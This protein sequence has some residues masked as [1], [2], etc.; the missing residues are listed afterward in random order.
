[1]SGRYHIRRVPFTVEYDSVSRP[2]GIWDT[3]ER[4][5]VNKYGLPDGD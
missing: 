1:M 4:C 2:Y 3:V 5:Y